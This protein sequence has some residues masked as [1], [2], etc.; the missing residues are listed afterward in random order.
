VPWASCTAGSFRQ[1]VLMSGN[2]DARSIRPLKIAVTG[3]RPVLATRSTDA[4]CDLHAHIEVVFVFDTTGSM[5]DKIDG[6][7][8]CTTALVGELDASGIDWSVTTV[9][10]GDLTVVGDTIEE[11]LPWVTG[12]HQAD[13][14]IRGMRRNSGGGN[15]GESSFEA[16]EAALAKQGR[17]G[18]LRVLILLTDEPPLTHNLDPDAVLASVVAADVLCFVVADDLPVYRSLAERTGGQWFPIGSLVDM[19]SI[20]DQL[21]GIGRTVAL[22]AAEVRQLGGSPQAALE[23]GRGGV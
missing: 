19:S 20:V 12:V 10:F 7:V 6:L 5:N 14:Q 11:H 4:A 9:P 15:Y 1:Y 21:A 16:L 18:A 3:G 2:N 17:S 23:L 22:R 8:A 13:A